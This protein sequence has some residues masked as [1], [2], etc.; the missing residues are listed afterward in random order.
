MSSVRILALAGAAAAMSTVAF[1]ADFPPTLP[2]PVV[3]AA[4]VDSGWYLRGD[5]GITN[6]QLSTLTQRLDATD[7]T[8]DRVGMGFDRSPFF[9]LGVGYQLN[10]WLRLDLTGEYRAKAKFHGTDNVTFPDNGGIGVLADNF[11]ASKSEWVV[12]A[13]TYLD[14]GTWWWMTPYVGAGVGF[15]RNQIDGFRDDG[16]GLN[17]LGAPITLVAFGDQGVKWNL[18][19]A[20]HAGVAYTVTPSFKIDLAYRYLNLGSGETGPT[21]AFDNSFTAFTF[22]GLVSHDLMLGVRWTVQP[23]PPDYAPPPLIRKG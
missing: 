14:L 3:Q 2:Q 10:N 20:L 15:S 9:L 22:N 19:W 12:L 1:A 4:P 17:G 18:A 7:L 8:L 6:Q 16:I 21:R 5:I 13:N 11:S 23:E